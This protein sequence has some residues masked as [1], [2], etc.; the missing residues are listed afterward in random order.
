MNP[1][2]TRLTEAMLEFAARQAHFMNDRDAE[3]FAP[4]IIAFRAE[5]DTAAEAGVERW[6]AWH[7]V[8]TSI[9][10]PEDRLYCLR[11]VLATL[12]AERPNPVG[13]D[14]PRIIATHK[15][16]RA[17]CLVQMAEIHRQQGRCDEARECYERAL[18]FA[19]ATSDIADDA[20]VTGSGLMNIEGRIAAA[21]LTLDAE[22]ES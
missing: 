14:N 18:S 1:V 5:L 13:A 19:R 10:D 20:A 17:Q 4:A 21:L 8:S 12:Q 22:G 9:T 11:R 3:A 7:L 6:Q 16:L 2:E 15:I